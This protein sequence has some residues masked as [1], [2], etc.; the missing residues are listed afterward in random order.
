MWRN[1]IVR[2][3]REATVMDW[4]VEESQRARNGGWKNPG[5][6]LGMR[7]LKLFDAKKSVI[8]NWMMSLTWGNNDML[9]SSQMSSDPQI[10]CEWLICLK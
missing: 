7:E 9:R 3:Q 2:H 8:H 1:D 4:A 10:M 5:R 6:P